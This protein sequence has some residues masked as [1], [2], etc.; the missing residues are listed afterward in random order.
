MIQL[1]LNQLQATMDMF[2]RM[3]GFRS[4]GQVP[5]QAVDPVRPTIGQSQLQLRGVFPGWLKGSPPDISQNKQLLLVF[6]SSFVQLHQW[7]RVALL[8]GQ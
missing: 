4:A 1:G 7:H 2:C 6:G 3:K 8:Q 5:V